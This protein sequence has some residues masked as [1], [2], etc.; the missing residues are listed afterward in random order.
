MACLQ[1]LVDHAIN[2]QAQLLDESAIE[3]PLNDARVPRKVLVD[4]VVQGD[5][6]WQAAG[7]DNL[8]SIIK[9]PHLDASAAQAIVP[10][11]NSVHDGFA[12]RKWRI[13]W[14]ILPPKPGEN[15]FVSHLLPDAGPQPFDDLPQRT[16]ELLAPLV[17]RQTLS[18]GG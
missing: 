7:A 5:M 6:A 11:G 15:G 17:T 4:D 14:A 8:Q 10:M 9:D 1:H 2:A 3:Q 18:N 13:L 16:A 12:H